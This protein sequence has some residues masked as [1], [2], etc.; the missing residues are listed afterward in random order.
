LFLRDRSAAAADHELAIQR[1][2]LGAEALEFADGSER[3]VAQTGLTVA[4]R[5]MPTGVER[6]SCIDFNGVVAITDAVGDFA[7]PTVC[8]RASRLPIK[9]S[10]ATI[11]INFRIITSPVPCARCRSQRGRCGPR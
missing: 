6:L 8:A 11:L 7:T 3:Q 4:D 5:P 2:A 10:S 9:A 1:A